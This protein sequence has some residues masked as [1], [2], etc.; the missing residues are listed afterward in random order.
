MVLVVPF[1]EIRLLMP[2]TRFAVALVPPG[3]LVLVVVDWPDSKPPTPCRMV[4]A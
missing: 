2:W 3:A 4:P 1:F